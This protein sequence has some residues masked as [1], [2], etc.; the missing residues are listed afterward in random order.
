LTEPGS[1]GRV[2]LQTLLA[3]SG[4]ELDQERALPTGFQLHL[5]KPVDPD[6]LLTAISTLVV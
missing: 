2:R 5:R 1:R 6:A 4:H 3:A